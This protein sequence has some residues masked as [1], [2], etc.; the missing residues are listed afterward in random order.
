[1][2]ASLDEPLLPEDMEGFEGWLRECAK[3]VSW[4][5]SFSWNGTTLFMVK[6]GVGDPSGPANGDMKNAGTSRFSPRRSP[7]IWRRCLARL[8]R[9]R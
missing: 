9:R 6:R 5:A 4:K 3:S 7:W 2:T 1:M 8:R